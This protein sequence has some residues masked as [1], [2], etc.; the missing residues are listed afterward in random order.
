MN[1]RLSLDA[2]SVL[3]AID[4]KGSFA[5]A[6]RDLHRVPSALTYT[7]QKLE[8]D[9][10]IILFDRA[11]HRAEM[12][13]AGKELMREGRV[14]L[15]AAAQ[16]EVRATRIA[17]G[18]EAELRI[19][20]DHIFQNEWLTSVLKDFYEIDCG[21]RLFI[22]GEVFGGTW[23]ALASGRA[24]LAVGA[25]GEGPVGGGY[26]TKHLTSVEMVFAIA[27][28]HPLAAVVEP[29]TEDDIEPYRVVVVAD[30]SRQLSPRSAGILNRQDFITV[31][32]MA[33]KINLHKAGIGV[34]YMPKAQ[35]MVE[36]KKGGLQIKETEI[37]LNRV[38]LCIAWKKDQHGKALQ[39]F[40]E[41][42]QK[43]ISA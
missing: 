5:A 19:A 34:G 8:Q 29:L 6:A 11:G 32:D 9:L 21:T 2:L 41:H 25:S 20:V 35:A 23:D 38:K 33:T 18:W 37:K 40:V 42:I 10:N 12:T 13:A 14:L 27:P 22:S 26:K 30:T 31:P 16:L 36:V 7:I 17:T 28:D 24:D 15:E 39:W 3:D 1:I 43:K 4:R